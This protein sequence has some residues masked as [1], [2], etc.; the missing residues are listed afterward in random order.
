MPRELNMF[1]QPDLND[2]TLTWGIE[3]ILFYTFNA[4]DTTKSS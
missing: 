1:L 4:L 2:Y 3:N